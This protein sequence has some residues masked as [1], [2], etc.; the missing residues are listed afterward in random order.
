[1]IASDESHLSKQAQRFVFRKNNL[2][3]D[4]NVSLSDEDVKDKR[5]YDRSPISSKKSTLSKHQTPQQIMLRGISKRIKGQL[6]SAPAKRTVKEQLLTEEGQNPLLS[7]AEPV[8]EFLGKSANKQVSNIRSP[9]SE[10]KKLLAPKAKH[11]LEDSVSESISAQLKITSIKAAKT[12]N[13]NTTLD[14]FKLLA[15]I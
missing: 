8:N 7:E 6:V 4:E 12:N 2:D 1:V 13:A 5:G 10:L 11:F 15:S 9:V 14:S 3:G